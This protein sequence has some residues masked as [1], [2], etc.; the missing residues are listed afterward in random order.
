MSNASAVVLLVGRILFVVYFAF[1]AF[2]HLRMGQMMVGYAKSKGAPLAEFG[3]WPV[4]VWLAVASVSV[5]LGIWPDIGALMIALWLIL[6]SIFI[7][8]WWTLTDPQQKMT[9]QMNF[10]RNLTFLGSALAL[11]A[12]FIALGSDLKFT[13]TGPLLHF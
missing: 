2:G 9:E 11:L 10:N 4:G 3:G 13:V 1:A 12:A 6:P 5:L 8:N 7:H